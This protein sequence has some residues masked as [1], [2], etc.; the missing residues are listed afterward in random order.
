[1]QKLLKGSKTQD[2][3]THSTKTRSRQGGWL[4]YCAAMLRV[5]KQLLPHVQH[6]SEHHITNTLQTTVHILTWAQ[7]FMFFDGASLYNLV[8]RTNLVHKIFLICF[9]AFLYINPCNF[10]LSTCFRVTNTRC[11]IGM[12]FSP[13]DGHTVV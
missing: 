9:I 13:D 5:H 3:S 4:C 12:I 8:N 2:P 1:V 11:H 6:K 7:N 10:K